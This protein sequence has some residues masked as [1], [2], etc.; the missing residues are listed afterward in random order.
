MRN[1]IRRAAARACENRELGMVLPDVC[2]VGMIPFAKPGKSESYETMGALALRSALTDAGLDHGEVQQA[3]V[4]YV[5]GDSCSGQAAC[6]RVGL[7][8]APIVNVNNHCAAGSPALYLARQ[9]V[10]RGAD[11]CAVALGFEQMSA[12]PIATRYKDR[13]DP[14]QRLIEAM[15]AS[16]GL[17]EKA[18]AA[19][20]SK[21]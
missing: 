8:A 17:D 12:G 5:Y 6:Y 7:T 21:R 3:Y 16:R 19:G 13:A 4:G 10:A 2:G 14:S 20:S 1:P 9:A 15:T 11:D 18:P